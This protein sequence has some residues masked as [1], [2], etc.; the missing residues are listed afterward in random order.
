MTYVRLNLTNGTKLDETH[1]KHLE[2]GIASANKEIDGENV[3]LIIP[4]S[5]GFHSDFG[6]IAKYMFIRCPEYSDTED[7][8]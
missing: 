7:F 1:F 2:D 5:G 3:T 8:L 6:K 4:A